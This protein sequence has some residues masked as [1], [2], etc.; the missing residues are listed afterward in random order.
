MPPTPEN[1]RLVANNLESMIT[2]SENLE[3]SMGE[4][5]I[6]KERRTCKT[7]ACHAGF[8][9]LQFALK[10][11]EKYCFEDDDIENV[12]RSYLSENS[13]KERKDWIVY[14]HGAKRIAQDLGFRGKQDLKN[15]AHNNPKLWGNKYGFNMFTSQQAFNGVNKGGLTL[16]NI[17]KHWRNVADRIEKKR[18]PAR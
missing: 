16:N 15:W 11:K 12:E 7:I 14:E 3:I 9:E 4:M 8:Y 1:I 10:N 5:T 18:L 2:D 6:Y 13:D 17:V